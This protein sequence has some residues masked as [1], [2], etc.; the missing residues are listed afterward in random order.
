MY[1]KVL[2]SFLSL[3]LLGVLVGLFFIFH[4]PKAS[5]PISSNIN[6]APVA[7]VDKSDFIKVEAPL[8]GSTVTSPLIIT[9][10]ARGTWFFEGSFPVVLYDANNNIVAQGIATSS[11]DWMTTDFIPFQT[12]IYYNRPALPTG[13][14]V[15]KKDNPSGLAEKDDQ[16][17]WPI[18]FDQKNM[19]VKVFFTTAKTGSEP[20]FDCKYVMAVNKQVPQSPGVA[21][22]ALEELLKGPTSQDRQLGFGTAINPNVKIQKLTI[23]DTVASVDF[24][25]QLEYQV[26]GSC[27]VAAIIAQ[28]EETLKQF[29]TVKQVLISIDGRTADI[30]QP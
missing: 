3:A 21:R 5:P 2:I 13:K 23:V 9:G 30:L 4:K 19:T 29:A 26:G 8:A 10:Q 20:D 22:A 15:L 12:I 25:E 18:V 7:V 11:E 27:R 1:K 24:N 16:L 6:Q 14:I 17:V 28:I